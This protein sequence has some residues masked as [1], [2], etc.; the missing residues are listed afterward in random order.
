MYLS[1]LHFHVHAACPSPYCFNVHAGSPC[2]CCLFMSMLLVYV[3]AA[4]L[5]PCYSRR[6]KTWPVCKG[7][8]F[9]RYKNYS[10]VAR[11]LCVSMYMIFT[12]YPLN[13]LCFRQFHR[14]RSLFSLQVVFTIHIGNPGISEFRHFF[15]KGQTSVQSGL[16]TSSVD[17]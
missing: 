11:N 4:S 9:F 6:K 10:D 15:C 16:L 5:C 14:P 3:H 12:C 13:F 2:P 8:N 1:I 7:N 17:T